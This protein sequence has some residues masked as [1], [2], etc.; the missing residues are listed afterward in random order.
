MASEWLDMALGLA[1]AG[2]GSTASSPMLSTPTPSLVLDCLDIQL[3]AWSGPKADRLS[4]TCLFAHPAWDDHL[5]KQSI[6]RQS[7]RLSSAYFKSTHIWFQRKPRFIDQILRLSP[8]THHTASPD[9][10]DQPNS[11]NSTLSSQWPSRHRPAVPILSR[12]ISFREH[13]PF[14]IPVHYSIATVDLT[15]K[16]V[17]EPGT[18]TT[19]RL[20][21]WFDLSATF[22]VRT[23]APPDLCVCQCWTIYS[24]KWV[25]QLVVAHGYRKRTLLYCN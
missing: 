3:L 2:P 13:L 12:E 8:G 21:F 23:C 18:V 17:C 9:H 4:F 19:P 25:V 22:I 24:E 14:G 11:L 15:N 6:H 20:C 5:T 1:R 16:S 7:T 10:P